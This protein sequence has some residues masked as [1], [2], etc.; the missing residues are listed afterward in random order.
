MEAV[1]GELNAFTS[2]EYT[3]FVTHSLKEHA[4]LSLDV[5]SDLVCRPS[6]HSADIKKEK[7]VVIQ[8]IHMAE[9]QLEDIIFDEYFKLV[10]PDSPLGKPILGTRKSIEGMQRETIVDYHRRQYT[11]DNIIVTAAGSLDHDAVVDLV[12]KHLK[13]KSKAAG[14]SSAGAKARQSK[15]TI[16]GARPADGRSVHG[17]NLGLVDS[18]SIEGV[19]TSPERIQP[20]NWS[21]REVTQRPAEQV[22]I[23]FGL[24]GSAFKDRLRFEGLIVNTLLGGGMTSR[25]YQS[26]REER[27]LVY[28]IFSSLNSFTDTGLMTIYAG[29]E[30]VKAPTVVELILKEIKRLK[31]NG[32]KKSDIEF[33]KTQVLGQIL[34]GADDIENRMNSL[35]VNEMVLGK[36]RSVD[37]VMRDIRSVN[38]DSV[39][40]YIETYFD[41][42]QMGILLMGATPEEP[43]RRWLE[44]LG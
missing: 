31:K 5:L 22:H 25:L 9:E 10:F 18:V 41:L 6:F 39:Q 11:P 2:R 38:L 30:P 23:L 32:L 17:R 35:G 44:Q 8:E 21:F 16:G 29:T 12:G 34:L 43:T 15:V 20:E 4:G 40:E 26:V 19:A 33:F 27:G 7:Q 3:T 28:S 42:E 36:Y 1:G 13:F 37:D 14:R 24:P